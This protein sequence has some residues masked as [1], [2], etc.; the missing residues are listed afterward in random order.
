MKLHVFLRRNLRVVQFYPALRPLLGSA[1]AVLFFGQALY[2]SDKTDN[3]YGWFWKTEEQWEDET[4]LSRREQETARRLLRQV[5]VLREE[6]RGIPRKLWFRLD[7]ERFEQ[8]A[9]TYFSDEKA[10]NNNIMH[11]SA[12]IACTNPPSPPPANAEL[13]GLSG[14]LDYSRRLQ[15]RLQ[16]QT[17]LLLLQ[18]L[19]QPPPP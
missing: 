6:F 10:C 18:R 13:V 14:P 7:L 2:W 5:G 4:S 1:S 17:H 16:Q 3:E 11:E 12:I 15:Q 8:L 9:E 19:R